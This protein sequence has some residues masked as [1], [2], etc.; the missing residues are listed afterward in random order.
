MFDRSKP[1]CS[2]N[3]IRRRRRRR[4]RRRSIGKC[5]R[6]CSPGSGWL[7]SL[8]LKLCIR[9]K[10]DC[11]AAGKDVLAKRRIPAVPEIEERSFYPLAIIVKT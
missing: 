9:T 11:R 5:A 1:T 4:R 6:T 2:A 3:G 7:A 10:R 8:I